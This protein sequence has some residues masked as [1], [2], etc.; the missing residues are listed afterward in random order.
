[1][2]DIS[3]QIIKEESSRRMALSR[4]FAGEHLHATL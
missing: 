2:T 3:I 4:S 1:M